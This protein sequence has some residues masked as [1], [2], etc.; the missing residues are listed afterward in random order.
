MS[1]IVARSSRDDSKFSYIGDNYHKANKFAQGNTNSK[2]IQKK[3]AVV[4]L[5][6]DT[7]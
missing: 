1:G 5:S 4:H 7:T 2:N 6:L 3:T